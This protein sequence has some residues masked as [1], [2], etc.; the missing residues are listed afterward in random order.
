MGASET[1]CDNCDYAWNILVVP[2]DTDC[3]EWIGEVEESSVQMG[4]DL[5]TE[6]LYIFNEENGSWGPFP[7]E[8]TVVGNV[9]TGSFSTGPIYY[10]DMNESGDYDEGE[11][12]DV[13]TQIGLTWTN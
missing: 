8:G 2:G 11:A 7:G 5:A 12:L 13:G 1:L 3:G 6:E 10:I 9:Y 4:I